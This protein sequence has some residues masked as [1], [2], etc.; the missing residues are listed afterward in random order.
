VQNNAQANILKALRRDIPEP[1]NIPDLPLWGG[2][3][4]VPAPAQAYS[5]SGANLQA[6]TMGR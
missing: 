6:L 2:V 5:Y 3:N 4:Y 1:D